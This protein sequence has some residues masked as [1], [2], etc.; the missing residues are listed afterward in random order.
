MKKILVAYFSCTGTT[1]RVAQTLANAVGADLYEIVPAVPYTRADLDWT[2]P[3]SRSSVEMKDAAS[4]PEIGSG[5]VNTGAYDTVF[6]GFPI[7]WYVAPHIVDTFLESY[8]FS[9]KTVVPFATSGGSGMGRTESVL[10]AVCPSASA[11]GKGRVFGANAT[12]KELY[13]WAK[14]FV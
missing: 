12:Q 10:K 5:R 1:R 7:W 13:D 2:N 8:D 6:V 14:D 3:E 11:W 9:G 4:R